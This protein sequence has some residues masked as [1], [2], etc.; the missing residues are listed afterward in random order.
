MSPWGYVCEGCQTETDE[1]TGETYAVDKE[2]DGVSTDGTA[3][4]LAQIHE[5]KTGHSPTVK[6]FD[7]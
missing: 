5:A 1:A 7:S 4:T 6:E 3:E 2:R